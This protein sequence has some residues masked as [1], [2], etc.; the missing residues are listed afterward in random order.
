ME[1]LKCWNF[2]ISVIPEVPEI[3]KSVNTEF[4]K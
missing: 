2:C 1:I 4:K 3:L